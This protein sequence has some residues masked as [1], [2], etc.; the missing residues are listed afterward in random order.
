[1]YKRQ[2]EADTLREVLEKV[3]IRLGEEQ[4][5]HSIASG[6]TERLIEMMLDD[7]QHRYNEK[8]SLS[9]YA[10]KYHLNSN[11]LTQ[12]FSSRV[13]QSFTESLIGKRI[14]IAKELLKETDYSIVQIGE[15]VGYED[16]FQFSKIFKKHTGNP[17]SAYRNCAKLTKN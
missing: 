10:R 3:R 4:E 9:D 12:V 14:E 17:P 1:M 16:Y 6:S 7:I 5:N 13:G 11:Y 15:M 2:V 8:L